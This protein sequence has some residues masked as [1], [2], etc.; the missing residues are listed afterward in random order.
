MCYSKAGYLAISSNLSGIYFL[1]P[2]FVLISN[3]KYNE[4]DYL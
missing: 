4:L 1:I 3:L 2:L